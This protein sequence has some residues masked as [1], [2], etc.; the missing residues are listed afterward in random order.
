MELQDA[1]QLIR[2]S[3]IQHIEQTAWADLGCGTGLFTQALS[4]LLKEGSTIY[5]VDK[6]EAS[7]KKIKP[8]S[9]INIEKVVADFV[10]NELNFQNLD[11]ILMANSLHFVKDKVS[12][13]NKISHHLKSS[14]CYLIV[15]YDMDRSNPWV[16][17]PVS[18]SSVQ[19]LFHDLGNFSIHKIH[20]IP[21]RYNRAN[22]YSALLTF[23]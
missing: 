11:G 9:S 7:L 1:I 6:N 14:G 5:A 15:E 16:P 2:N 12:F 8:Q 17:Y 22:I 23:L 10:R 20:E 21:S 19:K 13:L 3:H 18:F 4:T